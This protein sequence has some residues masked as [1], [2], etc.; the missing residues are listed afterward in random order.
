MRPKSMK[1]LK[2][3]GETAL[4]ETQAPATRRVRGLRDVMQS[5]KV[6]GRSVPA[7][8]SQQLSEI[9]WLDREL[10]RLRREANILE[11]NATRVTARIQ[12]VVERRDDVM[13]V[14]RKDLGLY[15]ATAPVAEPVRKRNS[16][17]EEV[18][19]EVQ[20]FSLEY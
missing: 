17:D 20:E 15:L 11:A 3:S 12:E 1:D 5:R 2:S 8:R 18:S 7:T 19:I 13:D 9:A 14:I 6:A 4:N 16:D 10:E